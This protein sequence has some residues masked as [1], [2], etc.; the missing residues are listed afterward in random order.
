MRRLRQLWDTFKQELEFW[1]RVW[2]HPRTPRVARW[3]LGFALVYAVTPFDLIPDF[4]PILGHLD[5]VIIIPLAV[6]IARRL[7]PKAVLAECRVK[8]EA[9]DI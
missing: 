4:I 2:R 3:L 8:S 6:L 1:R 7:V 5:D 9:I